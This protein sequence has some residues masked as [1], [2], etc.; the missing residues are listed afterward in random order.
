MLTVTFD[1]AAMKK[2]SVFE[3]R[4]RL[5]GQEDAKYDSRSRHPKAHATCKNLKNLTQVKGDKQ[6]IAK[7]LNLKSETVRKIRFGNFET[8]MHS[9]SLKT[10]RKVEVS[11][12]F[13]RFSTLWLLV[14]PKSENCNKGMPDSWCFWYPK[15]C[16]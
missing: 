8:V 3:W 16:G 2:L 10:N 13:S 6:V 4:I 12:W 14:F 9:F 15:V 7:D 1:E 11:A 5:K